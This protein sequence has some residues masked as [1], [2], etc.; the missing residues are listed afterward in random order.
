MIFILRFTIS[1]KVTVI[2]INLLCGKQ[3][4]V[5]LQRV[6]LCRPAISARG[7]F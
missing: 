6:L 4:F 3:Q 2:T 1:Q 5:G 7:G